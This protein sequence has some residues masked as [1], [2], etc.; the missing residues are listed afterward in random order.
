MGEAERRRREFIWS[1]HPDRGGDPGVFI[2][3]MRLFDAGRESPGLE[4][5][6]RVV[7]VRHRSW[8]ARLVVAAG[9][10]LGSGKRVPRVR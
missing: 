5:R 3:G 9:R 8:V 10:R 7:I 6:P 4:P 1:H 2:A